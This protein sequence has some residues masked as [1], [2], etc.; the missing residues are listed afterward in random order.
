VNCKTDCCFTVASHIISLAIRASTNC[1]THDS[2]AKH[3]ACQFYL[4]CFGVI[5]QKGRSRAKKT[6]P[7]TG[8]TLQLFREDNLFQKF[9]VFL[10]IFGCSMSEGLMNV[11]SSLTDGIRI[12][13]Y[14]LCKVCVG[15]MIIEGSMAEVRT[16]ITSGHTSYLEVLST[17]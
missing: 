12:N 16:A 8:I 6:H 2:S 4:K 17:P 9:S 1:N 5:C 11:K 15:G 10:L 7:K 3:S 14:L 13:H